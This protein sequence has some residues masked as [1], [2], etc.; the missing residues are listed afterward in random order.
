MPNLQNKLIEDF[1]PR[2]PEYRG[3]AESR[4]L[5]KI[6]EEQ[7]DVSLLFDTQF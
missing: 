2:P 3:D 7:L 6:K 5:N 4:M 1:D